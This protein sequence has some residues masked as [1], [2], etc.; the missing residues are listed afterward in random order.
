MQHLDEG[1]IHAWLDGELTAEEAARVELHVASCASCSDAVA[2]ARGLIAA[3]SR[4]LTA[5]DDV[6]R[7]IPAGQDA[8][9]VP[10]G[11]RD[12][13]AVWRIAAVLA[14]VAGGG[15]LTLAVHRDPAT[16]AEVQLA[17]EPASEVELAV[18]DAPAAD[19][20]RPV[21]PPSPPPAARAERARAAVGSGA[22]ASRR[23]R[24]RDLDV[25]KAAD[26]AIVQDYL[27]A[28]A[29]STASPARTD[30]TLRTLPIVAAKRAEQ[31]SQADA[32]SVSEQVGG[33]LAPRRRALDAA[34]R[35]TEPV[36]PEARLSRRAREAAPPQL[37][38]EE[39][40]LDEGRV[41]LRRVYRVDGIL[42]TLDERQLV[43]EQAENAFEQ[44]RAAGAPA[45]P[46]SDSIRSPA[47][48]VPVS[49]IRWVDARGA[50][51]VL[52]GPASESQLERIRKL[53]GYEPGR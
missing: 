1:T 36:T 15:A 26:I 28:A 21:T 29:P 23:T 7:A 46:P 5:L 25:S 16:R 17:S 40:M 49:S 31:S 34:G 8:S 41:V 3:S 2:E 39:R 52:S 42:V 43:A 6:P 38:S 30:D 24:E 9:R 11:R 27:A 48:A 47:N 4:I 51:F 14:L 33:V 50:E 45:A 18:A 22:P 53:L 20:T 19:E 44:R 37:L 32:P 13:L 35:F 10:A 12:R